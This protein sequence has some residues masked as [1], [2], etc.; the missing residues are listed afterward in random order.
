M[1]AAPVIYPREPYSMARRLVVSLL[2][3]L[4]FRGG[5]VRGDMTLTSSVQ[6]LLLDRFSLRNKL[7]RAKLPTEETERETTDTTLNTVTTQP[8]NLPDEYPICLFKKTSQNFRNPINRC[9]KNCTA[10]KML[11]TNLFA[12][13][14]T[15]KTKQQT[16][17]PPEGQHY[18]C[19]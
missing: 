2:L 18:N 5:T 16:T 14:T 17:L 8:T 9:T 19:K 6:S 7:V 4:L 11:T 3:S 13:S 15:K 1:A 10:C 12:R